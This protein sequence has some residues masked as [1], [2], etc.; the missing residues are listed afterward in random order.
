MPAWMP[1]APDN[2]NALATHRCSV[3]RSPRNG[4]LMPWYVK[5]ED[6]IVEHHVVPALCVNDEPLLLSTWRFAA[7]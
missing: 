2:L 7:C 5:V 6:G 4:K 1:P 3:F